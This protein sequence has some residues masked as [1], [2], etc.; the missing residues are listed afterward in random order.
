ME[1]LENKVAEL[2]RKTQG[3]IVALLQEGVSHEAIARR[4]RCSA[5]T[6]YNVARKHGLRRTDRIPAKEDSNEASPKFNNRQTV[7]GVITTAESQARPGGLAGGK[8][9]RL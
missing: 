3:E 5:R 8:H 1:A 7:E 2:I 4:V 6:V 9:G